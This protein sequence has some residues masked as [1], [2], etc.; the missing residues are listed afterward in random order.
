MYKTIMNR[1]TLVIPIV[2]N[3]KEPVTYK[4]KKTIQQPPKDFWDKFQSILNLI[5]N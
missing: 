3:F 2:N 5:L 4:V 1:P